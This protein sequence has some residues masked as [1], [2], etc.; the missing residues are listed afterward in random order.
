MTARFH[1]FEEDGARRFIRRLMIVERHDHLHMQR[2]A[3]TVETCQG[4]ISSHESIY[5]SRYAVYQKNAE[6][7]ANYRQD[8]MGLSPKD[9]HM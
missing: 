9:V 3:A 4:Q 8:F 7:H 2:D 1:T 5:Q 6:G